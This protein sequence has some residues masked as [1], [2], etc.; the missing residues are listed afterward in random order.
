MKV[1]LFLVL[2]L[3]ASACNGIHQTNPTLRELPTDS[4]WSKNGIDY[5]QPVWEIVKSE[6]DGLNV[7]HVAVPVKNNNSTPTEVG[8]SFELWSS[9]DNSGNVL[10]TCSTNA[11]MGPNSVG[12]NYVVSSNSKA[13]MQCINTIYVPIDD[14]DFSSY[15][16]RHGVIVTPLDEN[17]PN[18]VDVLDTGF[19]K[20]GEDVN[21]VRYT[22]YAR[23]QSTS[24]RDFT[25]RF[26]VLDEQGVQFMGCETDNEL[27][28]ETEVRV[29]CEVAYNTQIIDRSPASLI[30]DVIDW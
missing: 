26:Y 17:T 3:F 27:H 25:T 11:D 15:G 6:H 9:H 19:E 8:F 24:D 10:A 13:I 16:L 30:V 5:E 23:V 28:S 12:A 21:N 1:L 18:G 22:L 4:P 2:I 20:T 7:I 29:E 14:A